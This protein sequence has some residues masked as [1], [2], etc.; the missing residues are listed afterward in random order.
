MESWESGV[1]RDRSSYRS[2]TGTVL[3]AL[4]RCSRPRPRPRPRPRCP[5]E[6]D[7]RFGQD[8]LVHLIRP[9]DDASRAGDVD[10]AA[11]A[12]HEH[13]EPGIVCVVGGH[14]LL[15]TLHAA[16]AHLLCRTDEHAAQQDVLHALGVRGGV[17]VFGRHHVEAA[18]AR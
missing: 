4:I 15:G 2:A 1:W 13:I 12:A 16:V 9:H 7:D 6:A 3:P 17:A 11:R 14:R 18:A 5:A 8:E 10:R